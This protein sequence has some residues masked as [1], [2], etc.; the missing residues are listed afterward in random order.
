MDI[1]KIRIKRRPDIEHHELVLNEEHAV[2][3]TRNFKEDDYDVWRVLYTDDGR[4]QDSR[5]E[6]SAETLRKAGKI[7]RQVAKRIAED[8]EL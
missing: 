6:G 8:Y 3:I 5:H 2:S 1:S 7:A 4:A